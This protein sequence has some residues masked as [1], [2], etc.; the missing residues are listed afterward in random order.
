[1]DAQAYT[2]TVKYDREV[3]EHAMYL[4]GKLVGYARTSME[5]EVELNNLVYR[6]LMQGA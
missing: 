6:L 1:M 3:K 4:N 2:K 5:A